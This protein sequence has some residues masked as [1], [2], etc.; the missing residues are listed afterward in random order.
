MFLQPVGV[1]LCQ[2][3]ARSGN[4]PSGVR[5]PDPDLR[6]TPNAAGSGKKRGL[7]LVFSLL[8]RMVF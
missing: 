6:K 2:A 3:T 5:F 1:G 8:S 7:D 4:R